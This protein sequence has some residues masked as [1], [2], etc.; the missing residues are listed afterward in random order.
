MTEP[1]TEAGR[2]LVADEP[3]LVTGE[4]SML[5][6][7]LAIESEAR[8][9]MTYPEVERRGF[10]RGA[11]AERARLRTLREKSPDDPPDKPPAYWDGWHDA[12]D[13]ALAEPQP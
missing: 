13:A 11:A 12:L 8:E 9:Q 6:R 1:T 3:R 5:T 7:V 10:L 4:H 2:A